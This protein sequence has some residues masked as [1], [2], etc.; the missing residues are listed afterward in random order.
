LVIGCLP[1]TRDEWA[2]TTAG[3]GRGK[4]RRSANTAD[5]DAIQHGTPSKP[6]TYRH[7]LVIGGNT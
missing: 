1:R 5:D 2:E 3:G 6:C 4:V 7:S